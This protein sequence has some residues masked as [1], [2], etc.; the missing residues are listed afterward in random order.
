VLGSKHAEVA[1]AEGESDWINVRTPLS[2]NVRTP[3][4][5]ASGSPTA[6][7]CMMI[8]VSSGSGNQ[9]KLGLFSFTVHVR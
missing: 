6:C 7:D 9:N 2:I 8:E 3:L 1:D 5:I 4:S